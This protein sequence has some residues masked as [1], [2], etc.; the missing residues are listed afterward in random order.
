M[1]TKL[2]YFVARCILW[3]IKNAF[4][5][6]RVCFPRNRYFYISAEASYVHYFC[7]CFFF[8]LFIL[9]Y[10]HPCLLSLMSTFNFVL[11]SHI[12]FMAC[13]TLITESS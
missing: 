10:L 9:N 6:E 3:A 8:F 2:E 7:N 11:T 1:I 4:N 12:I 13:T 5:Q